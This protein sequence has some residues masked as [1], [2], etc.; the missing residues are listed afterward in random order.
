MERCTVTTP[1]ARMSRFDT[2]HRSTSR[3]VFQT[4]P[5]SMPLNF[6]EQAIANAIHSMGLPVSLMRILC[7]PDDHMQDGLVLG[8]AEVF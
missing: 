8:D 2:G 4:R 5:D 1:L 6:H 7:R 3:P